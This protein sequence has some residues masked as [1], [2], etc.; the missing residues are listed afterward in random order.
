VFLGEVAHETVQGDEVG[1]P[2][3]VDRAGEIY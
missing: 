3:A 1:F 2:A